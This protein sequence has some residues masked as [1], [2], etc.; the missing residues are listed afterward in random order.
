VTYGW[1]IPPSGR[2]PFSSDRSRSASWRDPDL[3]LVADSGIR[4][5]ARLAT[6]VALREGDLVNLQV[7]DPVLAY[8][9]P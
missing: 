9:A 8:L 5:S 3:D 4:M 7:V 2:S 6:P 1:W